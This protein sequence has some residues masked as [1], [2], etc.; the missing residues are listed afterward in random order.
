MVGQT[1]SHYRILEKLGEG[2]MGVVYKAVDTQL[3]R[4]VA[5]KF[6]QIQDGDG[7]ELR[8]RF[9]REAKA[10]AALDHPAVCTIHECGEAE[11]RMFLAMAYIDG[12]TVSEKIRERPLKIGEALDIAM[13]AAE[14][15]RAAHAAGIVHR[16]IK[17]ANIMVTRQGQVKIT[18]FGLAHLADRTRLTRT[19]TALGTPAYMSPEQAQAQPVDRR[20]DIWS[21]GVVLY[22]MATGRTPWEGDREEA[23]LYANRASC[24]RADHGV[25]RGRTGGVGPDCGQGAGEESG[26]SV[27]AC[28]RPDCRF[29]GAE[30]ADGIGRVA[31]GKRCRCGERAGVD[32]VRDVRGARNGER[33]CGVAVD[34]ALR[35]E[36]RPIAAAAA[37]ILIHSRLAVR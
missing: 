27:P 15:L 24:A 12:S 34:G 14:G 4:T 11:G 9:L 8:E 37:T 6:L 36:S 1:I 20:S 18:D 33:V 13:Q 30:E 25:A 23:V 19:K 28:G 16:D 10:A 26:R 2:G 17:S 31:G 21:L 22:A 3:E 35:P 5:L 29:V 32:V 7:G